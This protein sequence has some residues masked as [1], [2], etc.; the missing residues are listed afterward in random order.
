MGI[1]NRYDTYP[2]LSD[3]VRSQCDCCQSASDRFA[4]RCHLFAEAVLWLRP[5]RRISMAHSTH[6]MNELCVR[7]M[8]TERIV[9]SNF[10]RFRHISAHLAQKPDPNPVNWQSPARADIP[11]RFPASASPLAQGGDVLMKPRRLI[12]VRHSLT[13][14]NGNNE[15]FQTSRRL[16][17]PPRR[18]W[19]PFGHR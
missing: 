4:T 17:T 16:I 14:R 12:D 6:L 2:S 7:T 3:P 11:P 19:D 9:P 15:P 5:I 10:H 8:R 18:P 13:S 1:W